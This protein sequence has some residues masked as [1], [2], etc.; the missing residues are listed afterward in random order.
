MK[1]KVNNSAG[2]GLLVRRKADGW[3]S[4][5]RQGSPPA[6]TVLRHVQVAEG[7]SEPSQL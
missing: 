2:F 1:G 4:A 6:V 5:S 7:E 3:T